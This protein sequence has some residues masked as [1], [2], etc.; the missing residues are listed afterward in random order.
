M[1]SGQTTSGKGTEMSDI[2]ER[3][4]EEDQLDRDSEMEELLH[5]EAADE[6]ESLRQQLA[7][8]QAREK[9][10][11][12]ALQISELYVP[13]GHEHAQVAKAIAQPSDSTAL[14]AMLKQAKR[15]A[16]LEAMQICLKAKD[17]FPMMSASADNAYFLISRM[18]KKLE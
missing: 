10:R 2:V 18:A 5:G 8:C 9:V 15:E 3:L 4:R 14:D 11:I 7:E 1:G 16:L 13:A 6:I 12:N 17:N